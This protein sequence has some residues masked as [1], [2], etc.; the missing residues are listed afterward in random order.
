MAKTL[1]CADVGYDC[2][3]RITANDNEED[4]ILDASIKHAKLNHPEI[5]GL[6]KELRETLRSKIRSLL[7]Q[8]KY[9]HNQA[10]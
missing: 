6:Q 3:Y 5:A 7:D 1:G 2:V 9:D 4:L 10:G 8:A